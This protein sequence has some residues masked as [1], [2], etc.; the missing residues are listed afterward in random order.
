MKPF[1]HPIKLTCALIFALV[2]FSS[3]PVLSEKDKDDPGGDDGRP[4]QQ[5][6][7]GKRGTCVIAQ[8]KHNVT[9]TALVPTPKIYG[10]TGKQHTTL[11][12]YVDYDSNQPH[13]N[14]EAEL[15]IVNNS[16]NDSIFLEPT[17][18][19]LPDTSGFT[20]IPLPSAKTSLLF[21]KNIWYNWTLDIICDS[22][23]PAKN[24][25]LQGWV[26]SVDS[27]SRPNY[28]DEK[29]WYDTIDELIKSRCNNSNPANKP[30]WDSLL[31]AN[32]LESLIEKPMTC[33]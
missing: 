24:I 23:E 17:I 19:K 2:S 11:W 20:S 10:G 31:T 4:T 1:F 14:L 15:T 25:K 16:K 9:V 3:S 30:E 8:N 7:A 33:K 26:K 28:Q 5:G 21:E 6:G 12:L 13:S 27:S 18:I 32:K 22:Q 29:Y